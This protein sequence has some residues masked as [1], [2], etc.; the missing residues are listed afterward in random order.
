MQFILTLFL[1]SI[2]DR[3]RSTWGGSRAL[4]FPSS[5]VLFLK[6]LFGLIPTRMK[7]KVSLNNFK[8]ATM[9]EKQQTFVYINSMLSCKVG[10]M[11]SAHAECLRTG[12]RLPPPV[13]FTF[14]P[15]SDCPF[16]LLPTLSREGT[17]LK[18]YTAHRLMNQRETAGRG[19]EG[20]RPAGG[21]TMEVWKRCPG[22][23]GSE[24]E[25]KMK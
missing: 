3:T 8:L 10:L 13:Q 24:N 1:G 25:E 19:D 9:E 22:S 6:P 21:E 5:V 20:E 15:I 17:S 16:M 4:P 7:S 23:E 2:S 12:D 14:W 18:I 11:Q